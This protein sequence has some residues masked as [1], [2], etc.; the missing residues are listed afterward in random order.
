MGVVTIL[1]LSMGMIVSLGQFQEI[2]AAEWVKLAQAISTEYKFEHVSVRVAFP[3][4]G[5]SAMKISYTTKPNANFDSSA[6]NV[7]ME[8]V[9]KF[10]AENYKG[11]DASRIDQVEISR[12]EVHGRGCFQTT[13]VANFTYPMP[14]KTPAELFRGR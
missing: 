7:E 10:G 11:R 2:P 6:Q 13:Y 12:S 9:A 1:V 3:A 4:T 8:K 14:K 5:P